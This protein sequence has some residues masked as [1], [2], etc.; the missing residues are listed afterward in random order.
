MGAYQ[1]SGSRTSESCRY[2]SLELNSVT[3]R[4]QEQTTRGKHQFEAL[5]TQT[6]PTGSGGA[7]QS[8]SIAQNRVVEVNV[9]E[10]DKALI[11]APMGGRRGIRL[12][13]IDN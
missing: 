10:G 11:E 12:I 2:S 7:R 1:L 5:H 6:H 8:T 4:E 9:V 3:C 13:S